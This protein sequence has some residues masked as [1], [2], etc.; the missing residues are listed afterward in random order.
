MIINFYSKS[1]KFNY[2]LLLF[3]LFIFQSSL[4]AQTGAV[5]GGVFDKN[6][7]ETL[8]AANVILKG[9]GLGAAT[10]PDGNYI[11]RGIP[12]G[13]YTITVSYIG[14]IPASI[15]ISISANEITEKDF[16][17]EPIALEGETIE[18]TAQAE[19]QLSAINQQLT[20]NTISN[21][22]SADRIKELPDI[23][24]A[25][26]IG[27][28]PGVSIQ[29]RGGEANKI[30][31]RGLSPKYN[32]VTI[33]GVRVPSTDGNDRS[34]DLSLI[35][36]NML[37][38]IEVKKAVTP[39]MDADA[40]GGSVDLRL[41][42]APEKLH[43][44]VLAKGGYNQ[45]L[46][47]YG[48][49][50]FA[51]TVSNRFFNNKLGAIVNFN[52]DDYDRSADKF[53]A[54]Y[55]QITNPVTRELGIKVSNLVLR[56]E[57]I[58]RSR[59]GGSLVLDYQI[60]NG[61]ILGNTFY[62][63]LK[64]DGLYSI[65][66]ISDTDK[67]HFYDLEKRKGT[68]SVF[69]GALGIEQD[70]S[71]FAF[72]VGL[73]RTTSVTDN[74]EDYT[75]RFG[76]EGN[77]FELPSIPAGMDPQEVQSIINIDTAA[78]TLQNMWIRSTRLEE[79]NTTVQLNVEFP[80]TFGSQISGYFKTGGKF[81]WFDR[82]NDEE[83]NGRAGLQY[84][85]SLTDLADVFEQLAA[86]LPDWDIA[87]RGIDGDGWSI[88]DFLISHKRSDFLKNEY[89]LGL[90]YS[91]EMM[92]QLTQAL[93]QTRAIYGDSISEFR[94]NSIGSLGRD[95][96]GIE[97][98]QA[99]YLMAE[100]NFGNLLTF[101]P[102]VRYEK[103]YSK[104]NGQRFIEATREGNTDIEP[105]DYTRIVN[106]RENSFWLPM[107][108]LKIQPYE[109]L[110]LRLAYTQTI[111][112]PD[113]IQ[114]AP[115]TRMNST[116]GELRAANGLLKPA[117]STNYDASVSIYENY[118]GLFT[119]SGFYKSIDD[120][121]LEVNFNLHPD[122]PTSLLP[123]GTNVPNDWYRG[124]NLRTPNVTTYIN[125]PYE[126]AYKG[127]ELDWQTHFWYLPSFLNG[128]ILNVNYTYIYSRTEYQGIY[129][130]ASDS[131]KTRRP[132]TFYQTLKTDSTRVGR[133]PD[134]PKHIANVTLGYDLA[135]FS[136]RFSVLFQSDVS[137][138]V[139]SSVPLFDTFSG[140]YIRLDLALKQKITDQIE[141]FTNLNNLNARPDRSFRGSATDNPSYIEYYG[142]TMDIGA[143]FRL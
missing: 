44:D 127:I 83:Q 107:F 24:A 47:Y 89:D 63:Q 92:A 15:E 51:G 11:I 110:Q 103:D 21:I 121:V 56:E 142:F 140:E 95:Y 82:T 39:D 36:S 111:T 22:V 84:G 29:R 60:P 46:D 105:I 99:A 38:G 2:I 19:G 78:T 101:I 94:H 69:T 67:R 115:I 93:K 16:Y 61:K 55:G 62:N 74:P 28:L 100:L 131:I 98:Y 126:A 88:N 81:R 76:Q 72:D 85:N 104:Y 106:V 23:N 35:S 65:N 102:G 20:S 86:V 120:L 52:I 122:V 118:I 43:V 40:F 17:L 116:F 7:N 33:N 70:Y 112:R 66:D 124:P 117:R 64:S 108:H 143:R 109:W 135:G 27:R 134:Q 132:L 129:L 97:E 6:T 114:Y 125:N 5:R 54:G 26:S 71:W 123:E 128:L 77:V 37:D 136:L 34:V 119:V 87:N 80:F 4:L 96:D 12:I 137:S 9:T 53:S 57:D 1:I 141:V 130:V 90:V 59:I 41:K 91:E 30:S 73:A 25:E 45:L 49:Y 32:T 42:E 10:D 50:N 31:I 58:K 8:A 139:H 113:Y 13:R 138:F 18:I 133:M 48:N 3:L 79:N 14:Y 75:W 68:N